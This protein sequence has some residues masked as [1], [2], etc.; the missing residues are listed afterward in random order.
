MLNSN[1]LNN[2]LGLFEIRCKGDKD[3]M[4]KFDG[5]INQLCQ[6]KK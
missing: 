2:F 6:E 5:Y 3:R 4:D 1:F